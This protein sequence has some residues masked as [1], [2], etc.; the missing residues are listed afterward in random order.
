MYRPLGTLSYLFNYAVLGN[1]E[2]P[3]GYHWINLLLHLG[4]VLLVYALARRLL[5]N[6]WPPVFVAALWAVHPVLTE[7][8]TNIVG[9]VDL[10]AAMAVLSGLLDLPEKHGSRRVRSDGYGWGCGWPR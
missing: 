9:R 2:H 7:S 4:N 3:E 10:L 1:G 5:K 6:F 8:V